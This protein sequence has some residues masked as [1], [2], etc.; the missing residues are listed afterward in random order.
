MGHT[1]GAH[2][3]GTHRHSDVHGDDTFPKKKRNKIKNIRQLI[4]NEKEIQARCP[5]LSWV[6]LNFAWQLHW[7]PLCAMWVS[8]CMCISVVCSGFSVCL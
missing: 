7:A 1:Y 4:V 2:I 3:W 6:C 8:V 5:S